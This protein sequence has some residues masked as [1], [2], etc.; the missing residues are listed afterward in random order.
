MCEFIKDA[1]LECL[2]FKKFL[3]EQVKGIS[4]SKEKSLLLEDDVKK[5]QEAL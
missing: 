1:I 3:E 5:V 4:D 2:D